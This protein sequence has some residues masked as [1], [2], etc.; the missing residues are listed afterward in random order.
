MMKIERIERV[1]FASLILILFIPCIKAQ[2]AFK[3]PSIPMWDTWIFEEEGVYHLFYLSKGDIGRAE[4]VDM[5][6]WSALP[7]IKIESEKGD[8]DEGGVRKTG[9][10]VKV[11]DDY[12]IT[13]G[14]NNPGT[15]VGL[16]ISR[17]LKTWKRYEKNPVIFPEAP[18]KSET[19][20]FRDLVTFY[21]TDQNVWDGYMF[22]IHGKTNRP[23]IV[24]LTSKNYKKWKFHEPAFISE[25]YTRENDGFVFLEVPDY[26]QMGDKHYLIFSSVRSRKE[27]T[28]GRRDASGTW[29]IVADK[30]EGPYSVPEEPLLLG[31]GHGRGDTYVGHTVT[32]KAQRLLYH[33]TWGDWGKICLGSPKLVHQNVDGTLELRFWKDL[34]KLQSKLLYEKQEIICKVSGEELRKWK[35]IQD[36]NA[37]DLVISC[38]VNLD[39]TSKAGIAWHVEGERAQGISFYPD[40]NKLTIGEIQHITEHR[41]NTIKNYVFDDF[42]KENLLEGDF[43]LRIMSREHMVEVYINDRLIFATSMLGLPQEGGIAW[44]SEEGEMSIKDLSV[45]E[46]EAIQ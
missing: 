30:K 8:W 32:Y 38:K 22:G 41:A 28:S 11:G 14:S 46:M 24:H 45:F 29:Y 12:Y 23:S 13:Y 2:I 42:T 21:D 3:P 17:D 25:D 31:Y 36:L 18:Y 19:S 34:E 27:F 20:D 39:K 40:E 10:T 9:C 44:W 16:L 43:D 15:V 35:Q 4:S 5:I 6:H 33:Q 26:F 1:C 7:S 37:Q